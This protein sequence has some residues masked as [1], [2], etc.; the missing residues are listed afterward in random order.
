MNPGFCSHDYRIRV[1][2]S[3]HHVWYFHF[4]C[5]NDLPQRLIQSISIPRMRLIYSIL[6]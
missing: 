6:E 4:R 1:L 2:K 5:Q 3:A